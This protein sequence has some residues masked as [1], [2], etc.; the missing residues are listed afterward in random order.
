MNPVISHNDSVT[1]IIIIIIII[2]LLLIIIII[3]SSSSILIL[4]YNDKSL[5]NRDKYVRWQTLFA[6]SE[7]VLTVAADSPLTLTL[8]LWAADISLSDTDCSGNS[9][10]THHIISYQWTLSS[11]DCVSGHFQTI[12][13]TFYTLLLLAIIFPFLVISAMLTPGRIIIRLSRL[14]FWD[15]LA[16]DWRWRIGQSRQSGVKTIQN[17]LQPLNLGLPMAKWRAQD[18]SAWRLLVTSAWTMMM[19]VMMMIAVIPSTTFSKYQCMWLAGKTCLVSKMTGCVL[20]NG[21]ENSTYSLTRLHN[22]ED[23]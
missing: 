23:Y 16:G 17:D 5:N 14:A 20:L 10:Y 2:I 22:S 3:L 13:T 21:I 7:A 19:M 18:Q 4:F 8:T 15:L 1:V 11:R 6:D 9:L 12:N